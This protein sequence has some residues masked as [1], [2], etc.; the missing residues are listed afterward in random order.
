MTILAML[1]GLYVC[2]WLVLCSGCLL[3]GLWLS[4]WRVERMGPWMRYAMPVLVLWPW[5]LSRG[6]T[7]RDV[8]RWAAEQNRRSNGKAMRVG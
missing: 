2:L 1:A 8:H 3:V 4:G 5:R 7:W 6:V